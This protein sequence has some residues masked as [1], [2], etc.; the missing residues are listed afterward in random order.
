MFKIWRL[1]QP[2]KIYTRSISG[3]R[4]IPAGPCIVASNHAGP[5]D[6]SLIML[7]LKRDVRFIAARH[8]LQTNGLMGWY[9]R[10]ILFSV[11]QAIPSGEHCIET[12]RKVLQNGQSI[13]I[14]PE[15]D[16][17]PALRQGRIH[18]GAVVLSHQTQIPI[19]PIHITE[20]GRLWPIYPLW[21]IK[22]WR[23]RSVII[24]IGRPISPPTSGSHL[25]TS[26]YQQSSDQLMANI[27]EMGHNNNGT[28]R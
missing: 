17:H 16:I 10:R 20:S 26:D 27:Y 7:A 1:F 9:H 22:F 6:S 23:V 15:G 5:L 11:G 19:V 14:F 21:K 8:L 13:G 3:Q 4:N 25:T 2:L 18:T 24:T 28:R 12:C